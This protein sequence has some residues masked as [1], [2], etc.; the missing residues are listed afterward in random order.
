[1]AHH[2]EYDPAAVSGRAARSGCGASSSAAASSSTAAASSSTAA[3]ASSTAAASSASAVTGSAS[4]QIRKAVEEDVPLIHSFICKL[5][6]YERMSHKVVSTEEHLRDALFGP[7]P[8]IETLL[9]YWDGEPAGFALYFETYS[10]FRGKRGIH[11]EDLFV[12]PEHRGKGIGASLLAAT[13]KAA[14]DRGGWLQWLVLD[15]NQPAIEF[16]KRLGA[17]RVGEWDSYRLEGEAL[18][19]LAETIA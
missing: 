3:A 19:R 1:M 7:R 9:A 18:A 16:Y 11:L 12:E 8:L 2:I 5:A 4:L 14:Q 15:W 10:T 17:E 6:E 13:A